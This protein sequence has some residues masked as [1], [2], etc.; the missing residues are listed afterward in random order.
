M[1]PRSVEPPRR[2]RRAGNTPL[3]QL[4]LELAP[5]AS[6][7]TFSRRILRSRHHRRILERLEFVRRF[8][9]ELDAVSIHVGQALKPGVLG[10]GSMDPERPGIWVRPLRL[11][12]FTIAHEFVHLLQARGLAPQGERSCDLWALARTPLIIDCP[13]SYLALPRALR[14]RRTVDAPT[15]SLLCRMAREAIERREQGDRRYLARFEREFAAAWAGKRAAAPVR[16]APIERM[17]LA[18]EG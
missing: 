10:W 3:E 18:L 4:V 7:W 5:S 14:A 1:R 16:R 2:A 15:A 11:A 6:P 8:F 17:R 9:P 13:P 12:T